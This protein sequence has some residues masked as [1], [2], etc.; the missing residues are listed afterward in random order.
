MTT[1]TIVACANRFTPSH[2]SAFA[3][4]PRS[5]LLGTFKP[6]VNEPIPFTDLAEETRHAGPC[7]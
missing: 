2:S 7:C 6:S 1:P 4:S 5:R 3:R